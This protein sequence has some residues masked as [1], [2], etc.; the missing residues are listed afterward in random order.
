MIDTTTDMGKG[1]LNLYGKFDRL[2]IGG[3][4]QPQF[5]GARSREFAVS[6]VEILLPIPTTKEFAIRHSLFAHAA[7]LKIRLSTLRFTIA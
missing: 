3:Y 7:V 5:Q 4:I 6:K 2:R 1:L